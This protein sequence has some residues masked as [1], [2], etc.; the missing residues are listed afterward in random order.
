MN[1]ITTRMLS[2]LIYTIPFI[3]MSTL[4][5]YATEEKPTEIS[6]E[7]YHDDFDDAD[8]EIQVRSGSGDIF[9]LL[10]TLTPGDLVNLI[11]IASTTQ[12]LPNEPL[13]KHTKAPVGRDIL[14]LLP[15]KITSIEYGGFAASL[16]FNMTNNMRVSADSLI[17]FDQLNT[18]SELLTNA[19]PTLS[20]PELMSLFRKTNI[21]EH[22]GGFL[23]QGGFTQGPYSIQLNTSLQLVERNMWL[24]EDDQVA[25]KNMVLQYDPTMQIRN[26]EGMKVAGGL[27]DTRLK[28]GINTLNMNSF[29]TDVGMETILPTSALSYVPRMKLTPQTTLDTVP[30]ILNRSFDMA[31]AVRDYVLEPRV[32]NNGHFGF[33]GYFESKIGVFHDIVNAWFRLSYDKLLPATERRLFMYKKTTRPPPFGDPT[34]IPAEDAKTINDYLQQYIVPSGFKVGV[35]PGGIF[36]AISS[37][38]FKLGK[39]WKYALGYDFYSQQEEKLLEIK[40]STTSLH[41]LVV[42]KT[43]QSSVRQH[44]L[45]TELMYVLKPQKRTDL[46]LGMGG[47][48][49]IASTNNI[50][51]DWTVY[52]KCATSF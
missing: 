11:N 52:L 4:L 19:A 21:Q 26:R 24:S 17:K 45:Y 35:Q 40:D 16:F 50:G 9:N 23:F 20:L 15:H 10:A 29:Q 48:A 32:G 44:K 41:D 3:T 47:D 1:K 12:Q 30:E 14:Y 22:K 5:V 25:V 2:F 42:E 28:F 43:Q 27:G 8:L 38:D 37:L 18:I 39:R 6:F 36:N 51:H 34:G 33:G 46:S 7:D 49:T 31:K 13:W